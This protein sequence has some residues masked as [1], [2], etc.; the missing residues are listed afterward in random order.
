MKIKI[1]QEHSTPGFELYAKV[2]KKNNT[3]EWDREVMFLIPG[4][5]GGNHTLYEDI[6]DELLNY[7]DLVIIDP[8][9]CGYSDNPGVQYCTM[10]HHIEDI[11]IVRQGLGIT[12]PIIHGC[13][14]GS[15]VALGYAI[16]YPN[17]LSQLILT[18]AAA[19]GDFINS[20]QQNLKKRGTQE[21]IDIANVLWKGEFQNVE[22][23]LT[24]YRAM[25]PMYF[26]HPPSIP[27]NINTDNDLAFNVDLV[28]YAFQNYIPYF[29]F[30]P[31]LHNVAVPTLIFSGQFDWI[32][33]PDQAQ[34]LH[35]K[36]PNSTLVSF[37]KCGHFPWKD[38][39]KEPFVLN[40]EK[41]L[42]KTNS[43]NN[44]LSWAAA[45]NS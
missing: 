8:R 44:P 19:S 39:H 20:A 5:P 29:D 33:D 30:R 1:T 42:N 18:S 15:M 2:I 26:Y 31:K 25:T 11:E 24:Y 45:P 7:T 10:D 23:F 37:E 13:S 41:F 21:Q 6:E 36:L 28:N 40:I 34:E 22:H 32:T 16:S 43:Y 12:K 4:G 17:C 38:Q 9:G 27:K 14:Y 35:S 3:D